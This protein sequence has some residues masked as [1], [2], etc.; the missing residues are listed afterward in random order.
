MRRT[1]PNDAPL[2]FEK[3]YSNREFMR[4]FRL[5]DQ[6]STEAEVYQQ[7]LERQN[8][9]PDDDLYLELLVIHRKYG[10]IGIAGLADYVP[11]HQRAEW[12]LGLFDERHRSSGYGLEAGLMLLDLAFN[13]YKLHKLTS[14]VYG[15]N[16]I[17]QKGTAG[18]GFKLIGIDPEHIFNSATKTF[19][20]VYRYSLTEDEFRRNKRLAPLSKRLL[21]RDITQKS[22]PEIEESQSSYAQSGSITMQAEPLVPK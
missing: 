8:V 14:M 6:P 7:L 17:A 12:L 2:L 16:Y 15:Y 13:R 21:S 9:V 4:L 5:N 19:V 3:A 22:I 20:D 10:P 1:V 18:G 11:F